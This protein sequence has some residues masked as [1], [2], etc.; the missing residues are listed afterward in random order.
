MNLT[1]SALCDVR[2]YVRIRFG[3][4]AALTLAPAVDNSV[5]FDSFV[6]LDLQKLPAHVAAALKTFA[7]L[8]PASR[9]YAISVAARRRLDKIAEEVAAIEKIAERYPSAYVP[10]TSAEPLEL[11]ADDCGDG[12]AVARLEVARECAHVAPLERRPLLEVAADL[13]DG[14]AVAI[15]S[16]A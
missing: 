15:I 7:T 2:A 16:T 9:A 12:I 5:V 1:E 8:P 10:L 13:A 14:I 3:E 11:V 6:W 4:R